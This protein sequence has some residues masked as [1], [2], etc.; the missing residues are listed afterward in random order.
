MSQEVRVGR[1]LVDDDVRILLEGLD[2]LGRQVDEVVDLAAAQ[3]LDLSGR[4]G[5]EQKLH[6][7]QVR[8]L[9]AIRVLPPEVRVA[10]EHH[11]ILGQIAFDDESACADGLCL[12]VFGSAP[13]DH[14]VVVSHVRQQIR[15]GGLQREDDRGVVRSRNV[16][17]VGEETHGGSTQVGVAETVEGELHV[18]GR[19]RLAV[20]ELDALAKLEGPHQAVGAGLPLLGQAPVLVGPEALIHVDQEITPLPSDLLV[21]DAAVECGVQDAGREVGLT[22]DAAV[23]VRCRRRLRRFRRF[24]RLRCSR[25]LGRFGCGR[26]LGRRR[27]GL[28][29]A[30]TQQHAGQDH[31]H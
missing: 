22:Q 11:T 5:D 27:C 16:G 12:S 2:K 8:E 13:R 19:E 29:K 26:R 17:D 28:L 25:R 10:L 7:I 20:A 3:R 23:P 4:L 24:G 30:R 21:G 18:L 1:L 15:V 31:Q 6:A 9:V 14:R